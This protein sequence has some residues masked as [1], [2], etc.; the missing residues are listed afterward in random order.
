MVVL[1]LILVLALASVSPRASQVSHRVVYPLTPP[2]TEPGA[3]LHP[4][5]PSQ[6]LIP[7]PP[8]SPTSQVSQLH[9]P[10]APMRQ[11]VERALQSG[12][13]AA[14]AGDHDQPTYPVC[15]RSSAAETKAGHMQA[16]FP[17]G[18]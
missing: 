13:L 12:E 1:V 15:S 10:L 4:R 3:P 8:S 16:V 6:M 2:Y 14:L 17:P 9:L 7:T 11:S 18:L 5:P